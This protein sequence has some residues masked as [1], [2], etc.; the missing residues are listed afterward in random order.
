MGRIWWY[1]LRHGHLHR[2]C[3]F[4]RLWCSL[5]FCTRFLDK[6]GS[7]RWLHKAEVQAAISPPKQAGLIL[8]LDSWT[9]N[10]QFH[11][12]HQGWL[13]LRRRLDALPLIWRLLLWWQFSLFKPTFRHWLKGNDSLT[14]GHDFDPTKSKSTVNFCFVSGSNNYYS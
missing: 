7:K 5:I 1:I 14:L 3:L 9:L 4:T 13:L 12:A 10:F 2:S 11:F 6:C 8:D